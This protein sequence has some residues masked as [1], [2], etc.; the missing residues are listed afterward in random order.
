M[1]LY[2][3]PGLFQ[4]RNILDAV[5]T[6]AVIG[7]THVRL[8]VTETCNF[9]CGFCWTHAP[10]RADPLKVAG[11]DLNQKRKL[12]FGRLKRL[13]DELAAIGVKAISFT[14]NGD[15]L[16]YPKMA[17]VLA[18]IREHGIL[19]SVTSNMAMKLPDALISELAQISWLR[20]SMNGGTAEV[21]ATTNRPRTGDAV[22]AFEEAKYNVGR[23]VAER[24]RTG[25]K[26]KINASYIVWPLNEHD[27]TAGAELAHHLQID[28]I[29]FRP[30]TPIERQSD[31]LRFSDKTASDIRKA[32]AELE[33]D[34]FKVFLEESRLDD[35]ALQNDPELGCLYVNHATYIAANGD[36]YP[37]CYTRIDSKFASGNIL[38]QTFQEFWASQSRRDKYGKIKFDTCHSC[39]YGATN[40]LLEELARGNRQAPELFIKVDEPNYFV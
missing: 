3:N 39:P 11:A 31:P 2:D 17:E 20:W 24:R 27:V 29:S 37:C 12:D 35:V 15:P 25:G 6:G 30:D 8:E 19:V 1:G 26:V 4:H 21:Y 40:H 33:R 9:S 23:L 5:E 22:R 10:E 34:D 28:T 7:P 38:N 32:K 16:L 36:I 18:Q 14:G 13:I